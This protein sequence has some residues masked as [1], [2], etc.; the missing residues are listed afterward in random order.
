M[1]K[2]AKRLTVI[3]GA[4]GSGKTEFAVA[5]A[6]KLKKE[7]DIQ[8]GLVDLD[9]VNPYFRSRELTSKFEKIGLPVISTESSKEYSDLPALSPRIYAYLQDQ[10]YQVV[11]DVGGDPVGARVLGRFH[12]Y[13]E[14]EPYEFLI[15]VNPYRPNTRNIAEV[16]KLF[17][18]L[19]LTSRLQIT[20]IVS[21][22]NLGRETTLEIW[23][24]GLPLI[25]QAAAQ[26]QLPLVTHVVEEHFLQNNQAFFHEINVFPIK[27]Q[28]LPPWLQEEST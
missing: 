4:F 26:F 24:A 8:V 15:V 23:Q 13:F 7:T 27:L 20:G 6:L 11:F 14:A 21:N 2:L 16:S 22:I 1:I 28:M 25:Q 12:Q 19:Q 3:G 9:I 18:E 17:E 5:Y 10:T